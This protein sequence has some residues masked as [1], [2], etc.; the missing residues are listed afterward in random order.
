MLFLS[1][2]KHVFREKKN[3]GDKDY[4]VKLS[5]STFSLNNTAYNDTVSDKL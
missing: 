3:T 1:E 4:I 5:F 2:V